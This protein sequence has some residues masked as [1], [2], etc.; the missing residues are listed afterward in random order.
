MLEDSLSAINRSSISSSEK[1]IDQMNRLADMAHFPALVNAGA[2]A[3]ILMTLAVTW[4]L[5]PRYPQIY[6]PLV[7]TALV[8]TLNLLPV[9]LLRSLAYNK[10]PTPALAEMSFLHDQHRFPDWVYLAASANMAFWILLAWS[11]FATFP[12]AA[13]L[14]SVLAVASVVT[15]S[16]V[17]LRPFT[18]ASRQP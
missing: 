3:N 9:I 17:L 8:L 2:T 7:W 10:T 14:V 12:T 11:L 18:H 4:W 1:R 15:F 16:P 5:V 6:A 13:T